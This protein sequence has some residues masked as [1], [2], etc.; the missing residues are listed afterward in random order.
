MEESRG[1]CFDILWNG[2]LEDI[3]L[4]GPAYSIYHGQFSCRSHVIV[5][6]KEDGRELYYTRLL[7]CSKHL[8]FATSV[9]Y[10]NADL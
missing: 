2:A 10:V 9:I 5:H 4:A 7:Y 6:R 1:N 8:H 3:A